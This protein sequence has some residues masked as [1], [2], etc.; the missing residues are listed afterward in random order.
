M[1]VTKVK[2]Q[3]KKN[4]V[5]HSVPSAAVEATTLGIGVSHDAISVRAFQ[6]YES[7]G[8]E[9]GHDIQDWLRAEHQILA[10]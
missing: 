6:M 4:K 2:K 8:G 5:I 9:Q 3:P 10:R 1:I 7:R